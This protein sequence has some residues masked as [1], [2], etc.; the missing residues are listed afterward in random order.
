MS[1]S[2]AVTIVKQ[3]SN[4][5]HIAIKFVGEEAPKTHK[6]FGGV[7]VVADPNAWQPRIPPPP[8]K[9]LAL[10]LQDYVP[11]EYGIAVGPETSKDDWNALFAKLDAAESAAHGEGK[12]PSAIFN[13]FV[14]E[15]R[16]SIDPWIELIPDEFGLGVIKS[17]VAIL[18][19]FSEWRGEERQ[20]L[21]DSL[22]EIRDIIGTAS[23]KTRSFY[24]DPEVSK[25]GSALHVSIVEAIDQIL[26]SLPKKDEVEKKKRRISLPRLSVPWGKGKG[27][28]AKKEKSTQHDKVENQDDEDKKRQ[29]K[30]EKRK[31]VDLSEVLEP[32]KL[33]ARDLD[34]AVDEFGRRLATDTNEQ[35]KIVLNWVVTEADPGIKQIGNT[36]GQLKLT[37][38][39]TGIK[40]DII[41]QEVKKINANLALPDTRSAAN[42]AISEARNDAN[43]ALLEMVMERYMQTID[44]KH[45]KFLKQV[46]RAIE[47]A[48]TPE[49][50]GQPAR[51]P[52][53][54][55]PPTLTPLQL[56]YL[57][58]PSDGDVDL[59]ATLAQVNADLDTAMRRRSQVD[60]FAQA[61]LQSVFDMPR[62]AAWVEPQKSDLVLVESATRSGEREAARISAATLFSAGFILSMAHLQPE[63]VY[64]HFV[65]GL[66][67]SR[68]PGTTDPWAGG[69]RGV[70]RC[71]AVQLLVA[72]EARDGGVRL[73]FLTNRRINTRDLKR[74]DV[75]ELAAVVRGLARQCDS[76]TTVYCA[77]DGVASLCRENHLADLAVLMRCFEDVVAQG[78]KPGRAPFKVL[79]TTSGRTPPALSRMIGVD[80]LVRFSARRELAPRQMTRRGLDARVSS[81]L[82]TPSP[83]GRPR[84]ARGR[85]SRESMAKRSR[86]VGDNQDSET[87]YGE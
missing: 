62:F 2:E 39:E 71:I 3:E 85:R 27:K 59:E 75:E 83:A 82:A 10:A 60:Q 4:F 69:P 70:L 87:D 64:L 35:A 26:Q 78:R 34:H 18:L 49:P 56:F 67:D 14:F 21:F 66:H 44:E 55:R 61:Q 29:E 65:C 80:H 38:D 51:S 74:G 50:D 5:A 43:P 7:Q 1:D 47:R 84:S 31:R 68:A 6:A 20:R 79:L 41:L 12:S 86:S 17:A 63:N 37:V 22:I 32:V 58:T 73:D 53:R 13:R 81:R 77:V 36:V 15:N 23:W 8:F 42:L 24:K 30:Q 33:A 40:Q 25:H 19:N 28:D 45:A 72:L 54:R 11:L 76:N 52:A 48:R 57:L 46:T 16:E 9:R